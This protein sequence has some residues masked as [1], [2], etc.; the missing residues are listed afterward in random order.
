MAIGVSEDIKTWQD[1]SAGFIKD[2]T[3]SFDLVRIISTGVS[4]IIAVIV[5]FIVI[6]I[7][8]LIQFIKESR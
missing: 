4:L 7:N 1:K 8:T 2:I 3:R 6:Y 5:I